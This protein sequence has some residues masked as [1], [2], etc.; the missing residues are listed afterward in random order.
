MKH[1]PVCNSSKVT[2]TDKGMKCH[3]CG[4]VNVKGRIDGNGKNDKK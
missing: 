2:S 3:K 1:C 4:Y